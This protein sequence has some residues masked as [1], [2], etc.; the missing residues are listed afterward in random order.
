MRS[1]L[2]VTIL[3][4]IAGFCPA[5][6]PAAGGKSAS[7]ALQSPSPKLMQEILDAWSTMNPA[8][9]APYYDQRPTDVFFDILPMKYSGF[10]EYERGAAEVLAAFRSVNFALGK[11]T[12]IHAHGTLVWATATWSLTGTLKNGNKTAMDGRW[13]V[14]WEKRANRWLIVHE[15]FSVPAPPP[16]SG[17]MNTGKPGK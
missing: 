7:S 9:A 4:L 8:N 2:A 12:R 3:L 5:Q 15:H 1:L 6:Q 11:D 10:A 13:T 17:D 14:L 16:P